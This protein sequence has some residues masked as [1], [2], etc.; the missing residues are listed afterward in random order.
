[1]SLNLFTSLA[2]LI[3]TLF[4]M[5]LNTLFP[6]RTSREF[7][8]TAIQIIVL[9]DAIPLDITQQ[10]ANSLTD[11]Y[12]IHVKVTK[13]NKDISTA[14]DVARQQYDGIKAL[15]LL[16]PKKHT[17]IYVIYVISSDLYTPGYNFLFAHTNAKKRETILSTH[18][19]FTSATDADIA[20]ERMHKVMMRRI[21]IAYGLTGSGCIMEFFNS[22]EELD[23][24]AA[25]YCTIDRTVLKLKGVLKEKE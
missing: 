16:N 7:D 4:Q 9:N 25:E 14:F 18:R 5:S 3:S 2:L 10:L 6:E 12:R 15:E 17:D 19:F 24:A 1:M 13:A 11:E 23:D 22:L 8:P 21:G 20:A